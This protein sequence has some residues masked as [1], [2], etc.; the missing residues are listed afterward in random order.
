VL[1]LGDSWER[2]VQNGGALSSAIT[3]FPPGWAEGGRQ[4]A[5]ESRTSG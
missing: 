3:T 1:V 2:A 5:G 4:G